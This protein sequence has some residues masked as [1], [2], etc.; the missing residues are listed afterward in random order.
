MRKII[1][2]IALFVTLSACDLGQPPVVSLPVF[3]V[4]IDETGYQSSVFRSGGQFMMQFVIRNT[5]DK[6]LTVYRGDSGPDVI[7]KITKEDSVIATSI[8]GYAFIQVPSVG[9]IAPLEAMHWEWVAPNTAARTK[10]VVL[11][12][13]QYQASVY[14]RSIDNAEIKQPSAIL[15]TVIP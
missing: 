13:G 7:F 8:D 15:F 9:K 11:S 6:V 2:L 3:F 14:F 4:L 5:S 12:P 1:P 10:K